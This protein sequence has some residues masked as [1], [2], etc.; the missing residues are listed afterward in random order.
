VAAVQI[1]MSASIGWQETAQASSKLFE[2][3][4]IFIHVNSN[5]AFDAVVQ[6]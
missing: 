5:V 2:L 6:V 1:I 4:L 3:M